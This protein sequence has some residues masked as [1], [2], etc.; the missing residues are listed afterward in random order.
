MNALKLGWIDYSSEHRDKVMAVLHALAEPGAVDELG[1]GLIRDGFADILFPGTSTIQTRAKYFFIVPYL[2]MELEKK[3][4]STPKE[5]IDQLGEEEV[6]LI[7]TLN[8][9]D[10]S[11]VIGARAGKKLKR[12]PS[13]IYWNGLRTFEVFKHSSLSLDNY[14]KAVFRMK[15][16]KEAAKSFGN[17]ESDEAGSISG[18]YSSTF[19]RCILPES[20][21]KYSLSMEL[22]F[23]EAH[24]LK[25]RIT[26][27]EKSKD[28]LFSYL[29]SQDFD[30]LKKIDD[31]D[32]IGD[33]FSLPDNL[34]ED[35]IRAKRFNQFISGANIRYNVILSDGENKKALQKWS[36]WLNSSFVK[37]EF[38]SFNYMDVINRLHIKNSKLIIFLR[39]WQK[40]VL[41]GDHTTIDRLIIKREIELKSRDRSKLQNSKIFTYEDGAW[42]G[43]PK[44]QYR[45]KDAK[46]IIE[47]IFAGLGDYN[48]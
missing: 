38:E 46:V 29:L 41:S 2:L 44:L 18:E 8:K 31:F 25:E 39:E 16:K 24:F 10:S 37:E 28:S 1:I 26:T 21:W 36:E 6:S 30:K 32:A 15:N 27:A 4:F 7:E 11:G 33:M 12:K 43:T 47:D 20:N 45:F 17:E 40:A 35:Y 48:A 3:S 13:N 42:V 22:S 23:D 9:E 34:F 5:L 19:W 14:A